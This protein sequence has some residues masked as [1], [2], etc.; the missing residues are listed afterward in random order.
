MKH[1]QAEDKV[2]EEHWDDGAR[3]AST[4]CQFGLHPDSQLYKNRK[5]FSFN[6]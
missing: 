6:I 2:I 5:D 1:T 3:L 4:D